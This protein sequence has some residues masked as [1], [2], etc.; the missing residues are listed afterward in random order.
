MFCN[1]PK[2][3]KIGGGR[4]NLDRSN[5]DI[6]PFFEYEERNAKEILQSAILNPKSDDYKKMWQMLDEYKNHNEQK[7]MQQ[8][9]QY[10]KRGSNFP[11]FFEKKIVEY[12]KL[13]FV[14]ID[15]R[16]ASM[17][18]QNSLD[19]Q[20]KQPVNSNIYLDVQSQANTKS[21]KI[22]SENLKE[23]KNDADSHQVD[24]MLNSARK[25]D[26]TLKKPEKQ[27]T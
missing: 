10:R 22:A 4:N 21:V 25:T 11:F 19:Q 13:D 3:N 23:Y 7:N 26:A 18:E 17:V 8:G 16:R 1:M 2:R 24:S 20:Q 5:T 12:G 14:N 9:Y 15:L 6:T 27:Q